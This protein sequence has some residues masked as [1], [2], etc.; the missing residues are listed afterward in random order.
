LKSTSI[1]YRGKYALNRWTYQLPDTSIP[2]SEINEIFTADVIVIGAGTSGK[3]AELSAALA[4]AQVIQIDRHTTFRYGG[5]HI[6]AIDSRLQKKLG[7]KVNKDDICLQL[8]RWGGNYPDQRFYR[9][10]AEYSGATL[11]WVMI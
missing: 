11:D 7:V 5:G 10:W 3:A 4:G 2:A 9:L 1:R 8:M 6:A